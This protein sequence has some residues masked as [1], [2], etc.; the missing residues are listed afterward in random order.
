[1][2]G[3]ITRWTLALSLLAAASRAQ[4]E[5]AA[6]VERVE[7]LRSQFLQAETL[8]FYVSTKAGERYDPLRLKDDFRRLWDTGFLDDLRVDVA[9]G[10]SGKIVTFTV[11]ERRRVQVVDYRGSKTLSTSAIE[12]ELKT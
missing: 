2:P 3:R 9:D 7:V 1:M 10:A 11:Q 12:D 5:P 6:T 8:L 4:D